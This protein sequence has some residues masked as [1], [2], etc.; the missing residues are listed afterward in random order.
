MI[1]VR[2]FQPDDAD[3][4]S[5]VY[6]ESFRTYL[7]DRAV[8]RPPEYWL[9]AMKHFK[10]EDF[11]NLSFV[12]EDEGKVI[13]CITVTSALKRGL[14]SLQRIGVDPE[15]AGKGVGK[16]LFDAA[17][18]FWRERKMRKVFTSVSSN[19]PKAIR[20]YERCGFT[21]E[22]LL[23]AHYYPDVDEYIMSFFY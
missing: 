23:R 18:K 9:N 3:K 8:K 11:D 5:E 16:M 20:F 12:A 7:G 13:G 22:A 19:N 15:Y 14:G 21:R 17:D 2:E 1:I 6:Y 4:A 10:N